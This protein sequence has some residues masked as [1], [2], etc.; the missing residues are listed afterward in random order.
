MA[1]GMSSRALVATVH[2]CGI[3]IRPWK[4]NLMFASTRDKDAIFTATPKP[5]GLSIWVGHD[6]IAGLH[7]ELSRDDIRQ[8]LGATHQN[9]S[10]AEIGEFALA[11]ARLFER[12]GGG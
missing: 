7:P 6:T 8:A 1:M 11:V 4:Y 9:L 10:K 5:D 2:A 12:V 3:H